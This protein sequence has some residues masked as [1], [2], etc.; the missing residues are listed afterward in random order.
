MQ[1]LCE[2]SCPEVLSCL[3]LVLGV[4]RLHTVQKKNL[5]VLYE[6]TN[7]QFKHAEYPS[8]LHKYALKWRNVQ[9][10]DIVTDCI[11]ITMY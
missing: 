10:M 3:C 8:L 5:C 4:I 6:T 1:D 7:V 9:D 2:L 11:W